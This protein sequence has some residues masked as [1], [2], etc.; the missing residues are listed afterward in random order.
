MQ[1]QSHTSSSL[2]PSCRSG[3]RDSLIAVESDSLPDKRNHG[4][5]QTWNHSPS[6]CGGDETLS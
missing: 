4:E 5:E 3:L 1:I 6:D 2:R